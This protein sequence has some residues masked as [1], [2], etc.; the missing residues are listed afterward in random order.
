MIVRLLVLLALLVDRVLLHEEL[1]A[2]RLDG[3]ALPLNISYKIMG[4][5][6]GDF[7]PFALLGLGVGM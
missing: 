3:N 5:Y 7:T 1:L 2:L 6:V 4:R